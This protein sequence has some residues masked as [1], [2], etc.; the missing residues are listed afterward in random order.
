MYN[1]NGD[2]VGIRDDIQ[3]KLTQNIQPLIEIV[4][5]G[6]AWKSYG[7][8]RGCM[9]ALRVLLKILILFKAQLYSSS[10]KE[11]CY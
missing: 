3:T 6:H 1:A 5:I 7:M 8:F 2:E 11:K 10:I 9:P 4:S